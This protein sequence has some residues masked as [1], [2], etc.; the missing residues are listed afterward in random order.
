M[1][2]QP[3]GSGTRASPPAIA[4]P[5]RAAPGS[6]NLVLAAGA[7]ALA[8]LAVLGAEVAARGFAPDYLVR[9]RGLHVFS[10][11]L[12][13]A[14][15]K[16][17]SAVVEGQR[18]T[19]QRA[20]LPR[21]GAGPPE[22]PGTG[23]GSSCSAT[24]SPS[25]W[26]SPTRRPSRHLLDVRD[27]GIEA[28]NLAVQG[29]DPGQELLV[30]L[31][32][33]LRSE[34]DVVVLAFCLANDFA[35]AVLPVALYDGRTPKPRFRLVGDQPGPRR[36]EPGADPPGA[37]PP[38]AQRPLAPVQPRVGARPPSE[39]GAR[40]HWRDRKREALRDEE[41]ALRLNVAIVRRMD[42][43]CRER[44]IAFVVAAF[45]NRFSYRSKSWLAERFLESVR[46][47]GIAVV[48]MSARF[49]A[50]GE[51][52]RAVTLDGVGHLSPLGHA[53]AAE[54]LEGE[55]A[56]HCGRSPRRQ[57]R[58]PLDGAP[59]SAAGLPPA[60]HEA[61]LE[62]GDGLAV[63]AKRLVAAVGEPEPAARDQV[64]EVLDRAPEVADVVGRRADRLPPT[65]T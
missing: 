62:L 53:I 50:Q 43:A 4:R 49:V 9:S 58:L 64:L 17:V 55:I 23:P 41:Y 37:A 15:R 30:L 31:G 25:A 18:V 52:F 61:A 48:D 22:A 46:A 63:G 34:P 26:A 12:G 35:E 56:D 47:T 3:A 1:I 13:W 11:T 10:E 6:A 54:V 19:L 21:T 14:P 2:E 45:P 29:Y 51:T 40:Q 8:V 28:G 33:G 60:L 38:V 44:G 32:E 27:N 5:P 20:R 24:P 59:T 39:G 36:L 16:G 57:E 42:A 7:L 65:S